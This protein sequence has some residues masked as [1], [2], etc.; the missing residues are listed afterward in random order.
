MPSRNP[1]A[2][3]CS[4]AGTPPADARTTSSGFVRRPSAEPLLGRERRVVVDADDV[5]GDVAVGVVLKV[6]PQR[7]RPSSRQLHRLVHALAVEPADAAIVEPQLVVGVPVR[8]ADPAS[9]IVRHARHAIAADAGSG[10]HDLLDFGG[11]RRRH[12]L[13]G[14]DGEDPVV[15]GDVGGVVPLRAVALP[16]RG[17]RC[18][19]RSAAR[20]STVSSA[21]WESTTTISSAHLTDSSAPSILA[22]SLRVMTVTVSFTW[23]SVALGGAAGRSAGRKFGK[24]R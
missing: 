24:A 3:R 4:C 16:S 5:I 9:E 20:S 13:V 7:R 10:A 23:G 6:V 14:V 12:A 17:S 18:A 8:A 15:G 21:L 2:Q 1:R 19:R 11:Q 22:A